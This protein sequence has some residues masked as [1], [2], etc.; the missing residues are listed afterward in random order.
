MIIYPQQYESN[1]ILGLS[2]VMT[3]IHPNIAL[4]GTP[5]WLI[6]NSLYK[7]QILCQGHIHKV[8]SPE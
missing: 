4:G 5:D 8:R 6:H 7:L 1:N 2:D 3:V